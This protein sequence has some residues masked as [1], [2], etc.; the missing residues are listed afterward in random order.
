MSNLQG[1]IN[2]KINLNGELF[3][4]GTKG[5]SAYEVAVQQGFQG[6]VDEWLA[7]L[8]G[9]PGKDGSIVF[10][11]LT[12]EQKEM[13][14]G[15][16]GDPFLYSDF[17]QEQLEALRGPQGIQG[18]TGPQG[19]Q[20]PKGDT[21]EQ[22]PKGDKGEQGLQ[23]NTGPQGPAGTPGEDGQSA[24]IT[25]GTVT[26]LEAGSNATVTNVGTE[27]NAIFN[28]GIPKGRDGSEG[29]NKGS[30]FDL[31]YFG[32][33]GDGT[34]D[35]TTSIKNAISYCK[36][37]GISTLYIEEGNYVVSNVLTIDFSNFTLQGSKNGILKYVGEGIDGNIINVIGSSYDNYVKNINIKGVNIDGSPQTYKGGTTM[38]TP[39]STNPNPIYKGLRCIHVQYAENIKIEDCDLD[40]IYGEGI[41]IENCGNVLI[42][43]NKVYD[44]G[45]GNIIENGQTGYDDFGDGIASFHSFN[46]IYSNNTVIN[47]RTYQSGDAQGYVCGRSGLEFEYALN[48]YD[49]RVPLDSLF[50]DTSK[51]YGL[52]MKNNFVYGYTKGI[53]LE[54]DVRALISQNTV[55]HNNIGIMATCGG[56]CNFVQNY[57][58][59]D[60]VGAAFQVG[61]DG[62]YSGIAISQYGDDNEYDN[63][64]VVNANIFE[65]DCTGVVLGK[66]KV[67]ISDN[68]FKTSSQ[69]ISNFD[70]DLTDIILSNNTFDK[71]S[72]INFYHLN[73]T[74][75][76]GNILNGV[77]KNDVL[78]GCNNIDFVNN[79]IRRKIWNYGN[80]NLSFRKNNFLADS[81][82]DDFVFISQCNNIDYVDN[83]IDVSN[84][85]TCHVLNAEETISNLL[86][87]SNNIVTTINR[88]TGLF[89]V[90]S[91]DNITINNNNVNNNSSSFSLF[92]SNW[93]ISNVTCLCNILENSIGYIINSTVGGI[94]GINKISNN[95]GQFHFEN[96]PNSSLDDFEGCY[97]Q[98]GDS[99]YK[100]NSTDGWVCTKSGYYVTTS[101]SAKDYSAGDFILSNGYVYKCVVAGTSTVAPTSTTLGETQ[102]T[103]DNLQW[104]CCGEPGVLSVINSNITE[105]DP[106]FSASASAG[107][108]SSDISNWNAKS[109][110]S[111]SYDDLTNKPTIPT[112]TSQ[113]TND[114][115]YL[116]SIPSGYV[117]STT[118]NSIKVVDSLP[119]TEENGVLYL[120]KEV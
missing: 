15:P 25:V 34:T 115:G 99:I 71:D 29:G 49:N 41:I 70:N 1:S 89:S 3:K 54:A 101:W 87:D 18:E 11:E 97:V 80:E 68:H 55:M 103:T 86:I 91:A 111:G 45:G 38:S 51:A 42:D 66:S 60:N 90:V 120:V 39:T 117:T 67:M 104:V 17:T 2:T 109:N 72:I 69:A 14:R 102:T 26:T 63:G 22:G 100:Y 82:L 56:Y 21:G 53:H 32:A 10:E 50:S 114:S 79:T 12:E 9:P 113:L 27:T 23:G 6:T 8:Q 5:Y 116:T 112:K 44:V 84:N 7:S 20:G 81:T 36:T 52:I 83:V 43:S 74:K 77:S 28:F 57:F 107:I 24:T 13:L 47:T 96:T 65:G 98:A 58:N 88:A 37:N 40:D 94:I 106:V 48:A 30:K 78:E 33:K 92:A 105:T 62:Y 76:L 118:I 35:D 59:S 61:Y 16:K 46:V 93:V 85:D 119:N 31:K 19:E 64:C 110:F 75:I 95:E 108:T 73:N 4:M